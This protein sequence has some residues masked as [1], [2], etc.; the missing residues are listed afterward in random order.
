MKKKTIGTKIYTVEIEIHSLQFNT[1]FN[2][3]IHQ[4]NIFNYQKR[5]TFLSSISV[6][7]V[8]NVI[9]YPFSS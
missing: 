7:A 5:I 6:L 4:K 8:Q 9:A 2:N 1:K 3:F